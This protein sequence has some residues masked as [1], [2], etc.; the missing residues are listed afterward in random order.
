MFHLLLSASQIWKKRLIGLGGQVVDPGKRIPREATHVLAADAER[1]I[2]QYG[3]EQVEESTLVR[4]SW[5]WNVVAFSPRECN[6]GP[7][8]GQWG[9][10]LVVGPCRGV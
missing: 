7:R 9:K 2:K 6:V 4:H 1:L 8:G 5:H 3:R 10:R